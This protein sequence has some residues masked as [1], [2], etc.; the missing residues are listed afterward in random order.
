MLESFLQVPSFHFPPSLSYAPI[1]GLGE[2]RATGAAEKVGGL[3]GDLWG[4]LPKPHVT[5]LL[6]GHAV[7]AVSIWAWTGSVRVIDSIGF[8]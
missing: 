7:V 5:P 8:H 4:L 3:A 1:L 6:I 2:G